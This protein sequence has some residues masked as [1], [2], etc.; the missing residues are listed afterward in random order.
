MAFSKLMILD[1]HVL[2]MLAHSIIHIEIVLFNISDCCSGTILKNY[3]LGRHIYVLQG[4][5]DV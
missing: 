1:S 3:M 4:Y 5:P 2:S